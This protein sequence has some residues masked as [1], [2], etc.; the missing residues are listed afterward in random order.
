[1]QD[2]DIINVTTDEIV[3]HFHYQ[4]SYEHTCS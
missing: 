1:L 3:S 4:N 2:A